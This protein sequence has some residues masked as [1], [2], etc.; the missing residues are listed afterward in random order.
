MKIGTVIYFEED[1]GGLF[2]QW[3]IRSFFN[4]QLVLRPDDLKEQNIAAIKQACEKTGMEITAVIALPGGPEIWDFYGGHETLGFLPKEYR[5]ERL[6]YMLK[7]GDYVKKLGVCEINT[8]AGFIPENPNDEDYL[9]MVE[10]FK[11]ICKNYAGKGLFLSFETGQETPTTLLRFIEDIGMSNV[12][13]NFDPANLLLYGK[14]NPIDALDILGRYI[15]GVHAKDGEYPQ[16]GK[17]LG[18]QR[19]VGQGR[20]NFPCFMKKLRELPYGGPITIECELT[21][22]NK[23]KVICDTKEYL[24]SILKSPL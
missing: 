20:V 21:T 9:E 12:G 13:V 24:Q 1:I 16:N 15:R 3:T 11:K 14:A 2:S 4:C 17:K 5:E 23:V 7:A 19:I 18:R 8:H 10:I 6:M 22:A